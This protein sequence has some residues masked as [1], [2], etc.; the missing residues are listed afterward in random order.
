ME[1]GETRHAI[2]RRQGRGIP[3]FVVNLLLEQGACTRHDGADVFYVDKEA[4]RRI[5]RTLGDRI[6]AALEAYLDAYVVLGD[7]GRVVTAAWRTRRLR[8]A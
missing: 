8:R 5:R 1:L 2:A 4:R 3:P 6:H 7:D